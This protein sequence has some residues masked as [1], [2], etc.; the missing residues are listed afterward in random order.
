MGS[1][2][3][4]VWSCCAM[5]Y[6]NPLMWLLLTPG[7][8]HAVAV[9]TLANHQGRY[10]SQVGTTDTYTPLT[11]GFKRPA[12]SPAN[13]QP[14]TNLCSNKHQ[15]FMTAVFLPGH[16]FAS[17]H[18]LCCRDDFRGNYKITRINLLVAGGHAC[19]S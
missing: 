17:R 15:E 19:D 7:V 14:P 8:K 16:K 6:R 11:L 12:M 13:N 2:E 9:A 3:Q 10:L 18:L 4:T 5:I 1:V